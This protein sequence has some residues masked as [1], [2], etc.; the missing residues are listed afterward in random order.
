MTSAFTDQGPGVSSG[1]SRRS[2]LRAAARD[3][4]SVG[5]G[6]FPLGLAFGLLLVQSGFH[7]WWAPIFSLTIYAGSL[8]FLA[9]GLVLAVTP[10]ASIA[11]TTLLVNFRHVFY[12]LSFPLHRVRG[13][14]ARLYSMYALTD[15][16]Y[17]VAATKDPRSL[18]SRRVIL[19]QVFCQLYWVVGGVAGALVGSALPMQLDGLDFALTALF[20]VLA[21]DAFRVRRDIPA[22]V[23]ALLS[24][25]IALVVARDQMLVVAMSLFV[26]A[27]LVRFVWQRR[28]GSVDA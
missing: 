14:A 23:L 24:A 2:D 17:A 22:P 25:L 28:R 21:V 13:K 6:L 15:E 16:A 10:L 7:W 5:F 26:V 20:V 1:D 3:T 19:I 27:L 12:A 9:I 18:S 8:E 11:M 4:V